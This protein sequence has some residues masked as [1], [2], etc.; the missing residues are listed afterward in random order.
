M[1]DLILYEAV[2][3]LKQINEKLDLLIE[4][5]KPKKKKPYEKAVKQ[6]YEKRTTFTRGGKDANS[7]TE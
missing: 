1:N 7:K 5:K 2:Q 4:Q 6:D 3:E